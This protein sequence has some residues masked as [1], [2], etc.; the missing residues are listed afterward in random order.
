MLSDLLERL[1]R[2]G[3]EVSYVLPFPAWMSFVL[4]SSVGRQSQDREDGESVYTSELSFAMCR[5]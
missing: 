5:S 2:A 3:L 4:S 1:K